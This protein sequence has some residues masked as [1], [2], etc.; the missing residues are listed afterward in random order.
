MAHTV[1]LLFLAILAIAC[2]TIQYRRILYRV[3]LL[4]LIDYTYSKMPRFKVVPSGLNAKLAR[5]IVGGK[6]SNHELWKNVSDAL[7]LV[8]CVS[9]DLYV[10]IRLQVENVMTKHDIVVAWATKCNSQP[11]GGKLSQACIYFVK[12]LK[13]IL[14]A[15]NLMLFLDVITETAIGRILDAVRF[16]Q[17]YEGEYVRCLAFAS[18]LVE[19]FDEELY[20]AGFSGSSTEDRSQVFSIWLQTSI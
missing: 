9:L 1:A 11:G 18:H 20:F 14:K 10:D 16:E 17:E 13:T 3:F 15:G 6:G 8:K 12:A 19:K 2:T 5:F 4:L 7:N